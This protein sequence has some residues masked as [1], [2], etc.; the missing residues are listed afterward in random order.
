MVYTAGKLFSCCT[1]VSYQGLYTRIEACT[2]YLQVCLQFA[3]L[4]YSWHAG[5]QHNSQENGGNTGRDSYTRG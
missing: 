4:H 5:I 3:D 1:R 2:N